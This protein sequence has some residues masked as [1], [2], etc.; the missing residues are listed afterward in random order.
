MLRGDSMKLNPRRCAAIAAMLLAVPFTL[1]EEE[2]RWFSSFE[3]VQVAPVDRSDTTSLVD[4]GT[5]E[6]DG[7]AELVFSF[8]G[9]FKEGVPDSGTVGALLIPDIDVFQ[10][11][12]RN[13]GQLVFPLE[14][15]YDIAKG[16]SGA[17]FI[18]PQQTAK[19]AFP[20]YR[21]FFYNETTSGVS[22][23]LFIYR[24]R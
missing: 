10:Y 9:E 20:R 6:T 15:K 17:I 2:S 24:T 8:A 4:G 1:A 7:F 18:S 3:R 12:L 5:V 21:V 13:E 19:V 11:L 23:S 14:V 22:V 16:L